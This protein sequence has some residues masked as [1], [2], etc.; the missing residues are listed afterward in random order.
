MK[1][2]LKG[3]LALTLAVAI[4]PFAVVVALFQVRAQQKAFEEQTAGLVRER[5]I[6]GERAMCEADPT[7]WPARVP[8]QRP[9]GREPGH[10]RWEKQKRARFERRMRRIHDEMER[11]APELAYYAY[12]PDFR[13][14]NPRAPELPRELERAL[15]DGDTEASQSAPDDESMQLVATRMPW[16]D[17]PCAIVLVRRPGVEGGL[18]FRRALVP[19][20]LVSLLAVIVAI[21]AAAPIVRRINR[22][23]SAVRA[24][25]D[26]PDAAVEVKG[27]DEIADLAR[28]F[29]ERRAH[30]RA[31]VAALEARDETL[32][33]YV[34]NTTHDVMLPLTVIQGHL[35][36]LERDLE[37]EKSVGPERI[38]QALEECHYLGSLVHNLNVAAKLEAG[39]AAAEMHPVDLDDVVLRVIGRN[40]P[41]ADK[42][43]VSLEH[44]VPSTPTLVQADVTLIEQ[45]LSNVVHNA[46]RYNRADGH[47]AVVLETAGDAFT[48]RVVDD[49]PGLLAAELARITERGFRGDRAR[50]R[51]PTGT[52]LGL[53][54]TKDVC[55]RHGYEL[56][57]AQPDE[58]GLSVTISGALRTSEA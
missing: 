50:S 10:G 26:A 1:L 56:S 58:G 13:S 30:I 37:A 4:L 18:V 9:H 5:M 47:V 23:T 48:L 42:R 17:G 19:A 15:A 44:A 35:A 11:R 3:R 46:I 54:I 55:I 43:D 2:R 6:T 36:A 38:T 31:H 24:S 49:G 25:D 34:A 57:F 41:Y 20:L 33:S 40:A 8:R 29:D 39:E 28:A 52:G 53:A 27:S 32:R 51:H 21:F 22:L 14:E 12:G 16:D 45:A 7:V